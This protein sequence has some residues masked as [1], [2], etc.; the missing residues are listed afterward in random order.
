MGI[1][2][3]D[4]EC[5]LG[6]LDT[7]LLLDAI[8]AEERSPQPCGHP[9]ACVVSSDEG[10]SYCGWCAAVRE[11]RERCAQEVEGVSWTHMDDLYAAIVGKEWREVAVAMRDFCAKAIRENRP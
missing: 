3:M 11:E 10:T 5:P 8:R 1:A 6:M 2:R 9:A 4:D 7:A